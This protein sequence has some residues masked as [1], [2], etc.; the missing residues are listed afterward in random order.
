MEITKYAGLI[1]CGDPIVNRVQSR[2]EFD[3][4][5]VKK[6]L[7]KQ[8]TPYHRAKEYYPNAEVVEDISSIFGDQSI[9][10]VIVSAPAESDLT[11]V[12]DAIG[13]GKQ[14]RVL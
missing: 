4:F 11:V 7:V 3:G 8:H 13:A 6:V 14:V 5:Q 10:L 12:A 1:E 2:T 9:E